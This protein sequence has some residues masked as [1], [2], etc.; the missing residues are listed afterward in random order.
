LTGPRGPLGALV[1]YV[2]ETEAF[3]EEAEAI[4]SAFGAHAGIALTH[5]DLEGNLRTGLR[6]RE[7]IGRAVGILMERHRVTVGA[8][9]DMLVVASQYS[10]RKLREVA[11][12]MA[13]TGEVPTALI[14]TARRSAGG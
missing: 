10:H 13:E 12:W 8:A 14:P 1:H 3:D 5:A 11:A 7:E 9:F 6:T 4:A 2:T